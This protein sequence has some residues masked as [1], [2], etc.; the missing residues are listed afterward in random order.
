MADAAH[1]SP[2]RALVPSLWVCADCGYRAEQRR[3]CPTCHDEVLLDGMDPDIRLWLLDEDARRR[4]A[5]QTK[6]LWVSVVS[7]VG[8]AIGAV[9][10]EPVVGVTL[11]FSIPGVVGLIAMTLFIWSLLG[12]VFPYRERFPYL[13]G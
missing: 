13:R 5:R 8:F 1:P 3:G 2:Y 10:V 12:R 4:D 9:L 11:F 6:L 7:V